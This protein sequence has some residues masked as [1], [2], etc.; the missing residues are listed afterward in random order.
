M[1]VQ[2]GERADDQTA[3]SIPSDKPEKH[4][5]PTKSACP[6]THSV[7]LTPRNPAAP[8]EQGGGHSGAELTMRTEFE[9]RFH[10]TLQ[11]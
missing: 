8:Q 6:A 4:K 10:S 7:D 9:Y 11:L 3:L 2:A 5:T 1:V